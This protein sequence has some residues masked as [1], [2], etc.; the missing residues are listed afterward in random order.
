MSLVWG[1]LFVAALISS[2]T[3]I[4]WRRIY[5]AVTYPAFLCLMAI[6]A[7][8]TLGWGSKWTGAVGLG[9]AFAGAVICLV[10]TA[11]PYLTNTGGAGDAK[12]GAV[13]GAALGVEK[14]IITVLVSFIVAGV[15]IVIVLIWDRGP[16]FIAKVIYHR[17][18]HFFVPLW[19]EPLS[20]EQNALLR[21][22]VPMAPSFFIGILITNIPY[23]QAF[24][25]F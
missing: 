17:I 22:P 10:I 9:C 15:L 1:I 25:V 14:G 13:I 8:A 23:V 24:L 16:L 18:G 2:C 5:N 20:E 7:L 6:N 3:D 21:E 19:I 4:R 12:L 11:I